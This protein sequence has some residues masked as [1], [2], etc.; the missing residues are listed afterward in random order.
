MSTTTRIRTAACALFL[1]L[2]LL[3]SGGAAQKRD[4]VIAPINTLADW[5]L[6][7]GAPFFNEP[8]APEAVQKIID[9]HK[10]A[11]V[12]RLAWRVT[13][14]GTAAY[15][16]K[17]REPFHGL[18]KENIHADFFLTPQTVD[19]TK[20]DFRKF[21]TF[22]EAI[23]RAHAA[24][25][26]VYAWMQVAGEDDGWGYASKRVLENRGVNTV[27][28]DGVQFNAKLAW[29]MPENREYLLGMIKEILAYKPDGLIL[30]FLKNQG[31]YRNRLTGD[32]GVALYGYEEP[33]VRAFKAKFGKDPFQIQNADPDWIQFRANFVTEFAREARSLT[34]AAAPGMR[35]LAQ[36][37]GGGRTTQFVPVPN[38]KPGEKRYREVTSPVRD[39]LSGTMADVRTWS[40]EGL[41]DAIYPLISTSDLNEY[42]RRLRDAGA[43]IEGGKSKLAAGAYIWGQPQRTADF[44]Q[45]AVQEFGI[46]E[47]YLG[48]SLPLEKNGW[49]VLRATIAKFGR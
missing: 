2:L 49:P 48:E 43:L 46:D 45:I 11:G 1:Q 41:F 12:K 8:F 42:R 13:D 35:L 15:F 21:D 32:D 18:Q 39:A 30:D 27:G 33:A 37:W 17:L 7:P 40:R 31:D 25:I 3:N 20:T 24:G 44:A 34:K 28:R 38:A 10:A 22:R 5:F 4:V 23:T 36:V 29:S 16:S 6:D 9:R 26:E 19:F 47:I 14:G